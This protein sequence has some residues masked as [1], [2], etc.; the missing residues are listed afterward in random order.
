MQQVQV[1]SYDR[2]IFNLEAKVVISD[3][4]Q[5]EQK[6]QVLQDIRSALEQTFSF[7]QSRFEQVI[8]ASEIIATI[9]K[10]EGVVKVNLDKL[11]IR[12]SSK[13]FKQRLIARKARWNPREN[14][15]TPAQ[16]LFLDA[17][18]IALSRS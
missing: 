12:G 3:R 7:E 1:D 9:Q 2:V 11:Y 18:S 6:E 4:Y 13:I 10:I 14:K 8:A 15:V 5:K 17:N 16:L